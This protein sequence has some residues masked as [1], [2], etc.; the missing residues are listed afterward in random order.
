[1]IFYNVTKHHI[2]NFVSKIIY[3]EFQ[4][5]DIDCDFTFRLLPIRISSNPIKLRRYAN[6]QQQRNSYEYV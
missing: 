1:M 3:D 4:K 6:H 5:S 2:F